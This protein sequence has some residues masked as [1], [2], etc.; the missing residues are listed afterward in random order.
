[1]QSNLSSIAGAPVQM[2]NSLATDRT[3]KK[4][5]AVEKHTYAVTAAIK[6]PLIAKR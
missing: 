2:R 6:K 4:R 3:T 5:K 1:M